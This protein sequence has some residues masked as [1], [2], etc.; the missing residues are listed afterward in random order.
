MAQGFRPDIIARASKR[1]V[2]GKYSAGHGL[3]LAFVDAVVQAHGGTI[4]IADAPNGGAVVT[5][6]LPATVLHTA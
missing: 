6:S 2:K 5:L 3:G 1:F 4:K